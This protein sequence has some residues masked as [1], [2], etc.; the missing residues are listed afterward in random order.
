MEI[1]IKKK[2]FSR[3][4]FEVI[5]KDDDSNAETVGKFKTIGEARKWAK[6]EYGDEVNIIYKT[7]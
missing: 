5:E 3:K 6:Q 1:I 4:S 7:K 2:G